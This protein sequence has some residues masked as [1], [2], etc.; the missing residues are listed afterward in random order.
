MLQ[1]R[2]SSSF[3]KAVGNR[4]ATFLFYVSATLASC[5]T[6]VLNKEKQAS[7]LFDVTSLKLITYNGG[8]MQMPFISLLLLQNRGVEMFFIWNY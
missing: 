5:W 6:A 1:Q 2:E 4:I 7:F 3:E 8:N